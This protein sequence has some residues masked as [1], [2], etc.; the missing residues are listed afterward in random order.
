MV[1]RRFE[2]KTPDLLVWRG[3]VVMS[4]QEQPFFEILFERLAELRPRRVLEVGFG[5]GISAGLIQTKLEPERHD[6]VEIDEGIFEDLEEFAAERPGVGGI[7]GSFWAFEPP[8][9]YDFLFYDGFDY[10]ESEARDEEAALERHADRLCGRLDELLDDGGVFC[11]PH[12]GRVRPRRIPGY[13]QV[14]YERLKVPPY[15]L[16]DGK[17]TRDAAIVCWRKKG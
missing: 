6:I 16:E 15:L 5:L 7:L 11:W 10:L 3:L 9:E 8:R 17:A 12:F 1:R 13:E 14:L 2:V 4:R